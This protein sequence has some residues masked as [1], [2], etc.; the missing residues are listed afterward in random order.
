MKKY[1]VVAI[2]VIHQDRSI[3]IGVSEWVLDSV[4]N[5]TRYLCSLQIHV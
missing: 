4:H 1:Y 2:T 5:F 3:K